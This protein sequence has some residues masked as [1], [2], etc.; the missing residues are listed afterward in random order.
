VGREPSAVAVGA[1]GVWVANTI[2][3]TVVKI[4]PRV[5]RVADRVAVGMDPK[6]VVPGDGSIWVAGDAS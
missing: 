6:V 4:D 2:D 1:G 5:N 3:R